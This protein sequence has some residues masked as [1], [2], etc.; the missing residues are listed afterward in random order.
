MIMRISKKLILMPASVE[1]SWVVGGYGPHLLLI[2]SMPA[3][4]VLWTGK[5]LKRGVLGVWRT[6][7][8][9]HSGPLVPHKEAASAGLRSWR[10][11]QVS[12]RC[13]QL[14]ST[15]APCV[16]P[17]PTCLGT[18]AFPGLFAKLQSRAWLMV[19]V[20]WYTHCWTRRSFLQMWWRPDGLGYGGWRL[21]QSYLKPCWQA[22]LRESESRKIKTPFVECFPH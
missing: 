1:A 4:L 18:W 2:G 20:W 17:L 10:E 21:W 14:P 11:D 15:W 12:S 7:G 8:C 3:A 16:P 5:E 13:E 22:I 6:A 9:E 19:L